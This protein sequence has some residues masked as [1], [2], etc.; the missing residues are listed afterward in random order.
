MDM[1]FIFAFPWEPHINGERS[2]LKK[3]SRLEAQGMIEN[4]IKHFF[5]NNQMNLNR[6]LGHG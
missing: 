5:Y 6:S 1:L 4:A 3:N 2:V